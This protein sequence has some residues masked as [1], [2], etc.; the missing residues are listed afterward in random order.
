MAG[1]S[2]MQ[3]P[4]N[5][6]FTV[7]INSPEA[8]KALELNVQLAN[9]YGPP[10]QGALG[11]ADMIQLM[12]TGQVVHMINVVA[13]WPNF[14]DPDKSNV[15]GKI[16]ALVPPRPEDGVFASRLSNWVAGI[17][18]NIPDE[19]KQAALAFMKWFL[20]YDAQYKYAEFGAVPIRSDVYASDLAE[21]EEF[22]WMDAY[23]KTFEHGVHPLPIAEASQ[24]AD[25]INIRLNQAIIQELSPAQALN[26]MSDDIYQIFLQSGRDTG[27]LEP[28]PE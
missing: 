13:A 27:Q 23:F 24:V 17:P 6:D 20:T 18:R 8:L 10:N 16:N 9:E 5:G 21:T 19:R 4:A 26:S 28:L 11:Q 12:S 3:D 15:V 7:V 25:I 2:I 14:D 1:A 22:R